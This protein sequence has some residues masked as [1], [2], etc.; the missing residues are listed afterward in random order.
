[1]NIKIR[2]V[3]VKVLELVAGIILVVVMAWL[4]HKN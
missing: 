1:M 2:T 4:V 3:E